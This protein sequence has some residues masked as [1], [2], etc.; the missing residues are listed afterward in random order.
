MAIDKEAH[1]YAFN[2]GSE[3]VK[4]SKLGAWSLKSAQFV[5]MENGKIPIIGREYDVEDSNIV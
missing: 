4:L 1:L 3:S 5:S 2:Y